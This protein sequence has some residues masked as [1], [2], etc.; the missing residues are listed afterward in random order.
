MLALGHI[1]RHS[2]LVV[3]NIVE[4]LVASVL[5]CHLL[6]PHLLFLLPTISKGKV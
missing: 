5:V 2:L 4:I 1:K 6:G 3:D